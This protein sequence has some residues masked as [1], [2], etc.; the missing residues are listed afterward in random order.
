MQTI[1]PKIT[2]LTIDSR[3]VARMM[4]K[5]HPHLLRD[6]EIFSNYLG[7]SKIGFSD[8]WQESSY[9]TSQNKTLKCYLITKKGCEFIAHKMTGRK[10]AI[11]TA[12][13]INR[14]HEMEQALK[15][16][17]LP[18]RHEIIKKTYRGKLVMSVVD[19]ASLLNTA[20]YNIYGLLKNNNINYTVLKSRDM[21]EFKR[22][23]QGKIDPFI[24]NMIIIDQMQAYRL[25][26]CERC[27][28]SVFEALKDYFGEFKREIPMVVD[29]DNKQ[30]VEYIQ[31]VRNYIV[32]MNV[33][34]DT[35]GQ[36][37]TEQDFNERENTLSHVVGNL[38]GK[39]H[40]FK[41]TTKKLIPAPA[42]LLL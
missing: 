7:E 4:S 13:Y 8:F 21:V 27:N 37:Q 3:E 33:I 24:T 19:M 34:L 42:G 36:Y 29:V 23:N 11:F 32:A 20:Y 12:T 6:L 1:V 18:Q 10:G 39:V 40:S 31:E 22:E 28:Q 15:T 2:R 5:S 16:G 30:L 38:F 17:M 14:F 35:L 26:K 41:R 25:A 9:I